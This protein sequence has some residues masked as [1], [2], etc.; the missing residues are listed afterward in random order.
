MWKLER[1][2]LMENACRWQ[3]KSVKFTIFALDRTM[4]AFSLFIIYETGWLMGYT[5]FSDGYF[6][7][8]MGTFLSYNICWR[9]DALLSYRGI[10]VGMHSFNHHGD[11]VLKSV[12]LAACWLPISCILTFRC[13]S[14]WI[15]VYK[16]VFMVLYS[17]SVF[18][19]NIITH[20]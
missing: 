10:F 4:L 5:M 11:F 16:N 8:R 3:V 20:S 7:Q 15:K 19:D 9:V 2:Q 13:L 14:S 12:Y 1:S 18:T 17:Y 6:L